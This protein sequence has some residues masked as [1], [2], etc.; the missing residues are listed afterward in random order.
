MGFFR[1]AIAYD[2]YAV[3]L[4]GEEFAEQVEID[5]VVCM[6][7]VGERSTFDADRM[8]PELPGRVIV[9]HLQTVCLASDIDMGG[10]VRFN[11]NLCTVVSRHDGQGGLTRLELQRHGY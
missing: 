10:S 1:D 6:A 2:T 8:A 3:F 11:G 5:D 9:L 4:N 7:V